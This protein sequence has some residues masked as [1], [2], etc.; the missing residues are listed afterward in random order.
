MGIHGCAVNFLL[1]PS[2]PPAPG[3]PP[4]SDPVA[5]IRM[6]LE[7]LKV[8]IF[9]LHRQLVQFEQQTKISIPIPVAAL[10]S[11]QIR[12]ENWQTFWQA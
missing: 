10:A 9:L 6:S 1:S 11:L 4:H 3:T 7:H 12:Q 2:V 5:T 8:M